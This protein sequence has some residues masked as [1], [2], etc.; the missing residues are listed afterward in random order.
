MAASG[1][2]VRH[3]YGL[4]RGEGEASYVRLRLARFRNRFERKR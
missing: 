2:E 3:R 1:S 4:P